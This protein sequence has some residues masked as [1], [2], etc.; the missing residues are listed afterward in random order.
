M[1]IESQ[2]AEKVI[3]APKPGDKPIDGA[4]HPDLNGAQVLTG[5]DAAAR[6]YGKGAQLGDLPTSA[7]LL[8]QIDQDQKDRVTG[9]DRLPFSKEREI[10]KQLSAE[11]LQGVAAMVDAIKHHKL[12]AAGTSESGNALGDAVR[13]FQKDPARLVEIKDMLQVELERQKLDKQYQ[14]DVKGYQE[15]NGEARALVL[16]SNTKNHSSAGILSDGTKAP[17]ELLN[18]IYD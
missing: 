11:E 9:F 18:F 8:K 3:A 2:N 1:G 13:R 17:K 16:V 6:N 12:G 15:K 14:I 7:E 5:G 4:K 10:A